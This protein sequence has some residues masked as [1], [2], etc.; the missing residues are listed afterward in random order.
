MARRHRRKFH[1]GDRVVARVTIQN[2]FNEGIEE[3]KVY[4]VE[5]DGDLIRNCISLK[6][7]PSFYTYSL[8][9]PAPTQDPG[10]CGP[11]EERVVHTGVPRCAVLGTDCGLPAETNEMWDRNGL[12]M[13][14]DLATRDLRVAVLH[15]CPACQAAHDKGVTEVEAILRHHNA[16]WKAENQ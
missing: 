16:L 14:N 6:R 13:H 11:Q 8:F 9:D 15:I 7:I 1:R 2:A 12:E 5:N 4:I 3:G 10:L